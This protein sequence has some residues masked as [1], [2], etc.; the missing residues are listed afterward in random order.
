MI[1]GLMF[2]VLIALV[3][4]QVWLVMSNDTRSGR[5]HLGLF[6]LSM[7]N[8]LFLV[9]GHVALGLLITS[10]SL[11][12]LVYWIQSGQMLVRLRRLA[13][14]LLTF[15]ALTSLLTLVD[16]PIEPS[17]VVIATMLLYIAAHAIYLHEEAQAIRVSPDD[18]IDQR[19]T[20]WVSMV[21][22]ELRGP[23]GGIIGLADLMIDGSE[24]PLSEKTV[25][26][27]ELISQNGRRLTH[28]LNDLLDAKR[29]KSGEIELD[30]KPV[31]LRSLV[32]R[33][34][35]TNI[36]Q[37]TTKNIELDNRIST[38]TPNVLADSDKIE[39]VL[40][41]LVNNSL[42]FTDSG[43][44]TVR[45]ETRSNVVVIT[46]EDTG[47]GF[48]KRNLERILD[49]TVDKMIPGSLNSN[50][51]GLGLKIIT[52]LLEMH[53]SDLAVETVEGVGSSISFK[54]PVTD[55]QASVDKR[56]EELGFVMKETTG[57]IADLIPSRATARRDKYD[58]MIVDDETIN[59]R[60][61][62]A[63]L[64]RAG[65]NVI[66][67][68]DGYKALKHIQTVSVPDLILLDVMM[69]GMN[70]FEVLA[71][72]RKTYPQ[73]QVPVILVTAKNQGPDILTGF[74]AGAND[75]VTKPIAKDELLARIKTHLELSKVHQ[76]FS[77]FVPIEFLKFLGYKSILDIQLGDQVQK[78]MTVLFS[79][80][81][82]FSRI[83]ERMSPKESFD[84]INTFLG[85]VSPVI[86]KHGGFI[87]KFIGDAI[88]AL[89]PGPADDALAAAIDI[90][91]ALKALNV[92]RVSNELEP[93]RVG[94]GLHTGDLMLGTVGEEKRMDGTVIS[95]AVNTAS[96][97][98][99]LTKVFDTGV[100]IS[101]KVM[102]E[103]A[104]PDRY[105]FKYPG[106]AKVKGKMDH[107]DVFGVI[108]GDDEVRVLVEQKTKEEFE[109]GIKAF[110]ERDFTGASVCF[111]NV[112]KL[113]PTDKAAG[114]FLKRSANLMISG[115]PSDW[116]GIDL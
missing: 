53:G 78:H 88:M 80:I 49:K 11:I 114:I 41:N 43:K 27:L 39:Q 29:I 48:A 106:K 111:N 2:G 89:F 79:D 104:E 38:D 102:E 65:Y 7:A 67:F 13:V 93:I 84:F 50:T 14:L 69:P 83:S 47:I 113:N 18:E 100:V 112:L 42:K 110:Y 15:A 74:Q 116:D 91:S 61:L 28:L 103:L 73:S 26:N 32:N 34:L 99:G 4:A 63:Q 19:R 45:A 96:R 60:V 90:T 10:G 16:L 21:A 107:V 57:Q 22:H 17:L 20:E 5:S 97:M 86:R 59:L 75:Y 37:A 62:N 54:L 24:T 52:R 25:S 55:L 72:V 101:S 82:D 92:D 94:T 9:F 23:V 85:T 51:T 1:H 58:I 3:V 71:E 108:E 30:M 46:V 105:H 115:V 44:I 40:F 98:E 70:G 76:A 81:K 56:F 33:V 95:D 68:F 31:H 36:A 87:D 6:A 8:S 109:R 77:Y 12:A 64:V 66:E 35:A